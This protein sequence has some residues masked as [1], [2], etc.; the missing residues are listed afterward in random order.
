MRVRTIC[1]F[2]VLLC[3][4]AAN[5]QA[6]SS[7]YETKR[8]VT[9]FA[10]EEPTIDGRLDDAVWDSV[11]WGGDFL[12]WEPEEGATPTQQ[13]QFKILYD[14][15]AL[16]F[17]VRAHHD[18][19]SQIENLMARRDRFPG[20]WVEINIDSY[21]DRQTAYSFTCSVSGTR[22]DE[23]ISRDG[24]SWDGNWDPVWSLR[25]NI[26]DDGW[27]AEARIPLSQ[28]RFARK[29]QQVWGIQVQ[30]RHYKEQERS[31]WQPRSKEEEGWVSRFG[32]L[33]GIDNVDPPRRV[34]IL[35][36]GLTRGER[37]ESVDGDPYLDGSK[38]DLSFGLDG[39]I[40][41][42]SNLTVDLTVN[43]DFGQ[44]EADPSELNLTAFETFFSER[45][46]FFVEG[47]DILD[48]QVSPAI[49][50]GSFTADNLFYS[51]R[52][53]K[54][55][56]Y[57]PDGD[58]VDAPENTSIL[59]AAKLS[60]RTENGL[61]IGIL[62]SVTAREQAS[63]SDGIDEEN[64]TVEPLTNFLVTRVQ[65]D[66]DEGNMRLGMMF[67]TVHR[68][69]EDSHLDQLHDSAYSGGIDFFRYWNDKD[70]YFAFNGAASH[71]RGSEA[72]IAET[73]T[74]SARYYQRPDNDYVDYDPTRTELSG[75]AGSTRLARV[76]GD[77]R[78]E[79][80]GTWRSPGFEINDVGFLRRADEINQFTWAGYKM[81]EPFSVFRSLRM[82]ANQWQFWDSGGTKLGTEFNV[83][84][85][86]H[87]KNN[88]QVGGGIT[89]GLESIS[90]T[91][92]RGGPSSKWPG[93]ASPNFWVNSDDSRMIDYGFG[94]WQ[95]DVFQDKRLTQ[96][97][98]FYVGIR[99]NNVLRLSV[100]P[101]Y[102]KNDDEMQYVE[103]SD[104]GS[105]DRYLFGSLDQETMWLT[106]RMD[107]SITPNLTV[108]YYGAPFF[109]SGSYS[110]FKRIT[111]PRA[112]EYRDRFQ[113]FEDDEISYDEANGEYLVDENGDTTTD[114]SFD[115]PNF[116]FRDFNSNLVLRW[117]F[118]L[119]STLYLVWSQSRTS[120]G[121]EGQFEVGN[122]IN[123][124]FDEH[125][126]NVFLI[127]INKWFSL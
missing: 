120:F 125:P 46:P 3:L 107:Y 111:E 11:E 108:Q 10:D 79:T 9:T 84:S 101:E 92:L 6:Q 36:Y 49:T 50:G 12:Q 29:D 53:G 48:F 99:P 96:G 119:G 82:N 56:S 78:F 57:Y 122:E 85:N 77:F 17:A 52:I 54:R 19:P 41:L 123:S 16:Y 14:N 106:F 22:G 26:D 68:N 23:F 105:D 64:M 40:G 74:S 58:Y 118:D 59:G 124:L 95:T 127:K 42:T 34:E 80:G 63:V 30:R 90:N 61:S 21:H 60:G 4:L 100:S 117:E 24:D 67:N 43:P 51:R 76:G 20:D 47:Q 32:E 39:K 13:T 112:D 88:Y 44:V 33:H 104:F 87:F 69:I 75:H 72:A 81:D 62:E 38:G 89:W 66:F 97:A 109:S 73:Q 5:T 94:G 2:V 83:N 86:A 8:Y 27:T 113:E 121:S 31:I 126:H 45:R 110:R 70:W 114:Y 93:Y 65:Q 103:T 28:L 98:W 7:K 71:V 37:F 35:P 55:P 18:D 115:N 116:D 15:D 1:Q 25:T 91:A 102:A